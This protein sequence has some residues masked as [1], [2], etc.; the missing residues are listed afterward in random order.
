MH[1]SGDRRQ[2]EDRGTG[3]L[4]AFGE[5]WRNPANRARAPADGW[6]RGSRGDDS[7][8]WRGTGPRKLCPFRR[9]PR[10]ESPPPMHRRHSSP[11]TVA[12]VV[13]ALLAPPRHAAGA[14]FAQ[15]W[16]G[17][18][19]P[20]RAM[21]RE[22]P[23]TCEDDA[24]ESLAAQIDW[25]EHHVD[26]FG[27]IV[28][29]QPDVWGQS[30]LTRYRYEYETQLKAKLGDFQDLNNASIQRSDQSFVGIAMAMSGGHSTAATP[31]PAVTNVQN[32]IS[33]P[34]QASSGVIDRSAPFSAPQ[35][36]FASFGLG[37]DNAVSLDPSTHLDHLSEYIG[38]LQELRRINEGDD[39]ADSPGY[40]LN[41]V[42]VPVS[43]LPG[44]VTQTGYGAEITIIADVDLGDDLLPDT[45]RN[46]VIND[47]V[48]L[49]APPITFALNSGS[50]RAAICAQEAI[51]EA[52]A[53]LPPDALEFAAGGE[54]VAGVPRR[55]LVAEMRR[56]L[57]AHSMAVSIPTAKMRRARMPLPPEQIID[58]GGELQAA[59]LV[60]AAF[61]ALGGHPANRPCIEYVD[62]RGYLGEELQGAYDFLCQARQSAAW[63]R[64]AEH[65]LAELV[66]SRRFGE[67]ELRRREFFESLG[68]D[69]AV[70]GE[71]PGRA[72]SLVDPCD[73]PCANSVDG[74]RICRTTTAVLAWT[75][76]VES[77]LLNE[78]LV[79]D[80]RDAGSSRGTG[81][82]CVVAG[83]FW[84]P[85]PSPEARAAFNDYVRRRWPIR[86]FTL[87]PITQEQ[88][89]EDMFSQRREMQ[90]AM[91]MAFASGRVNSSAMTRYARRLETDIATIGLNKTAVGFTHGAD[92]FGW[93]FYP[94]VQT[95]PTKGNLQTFAETLCGPANSTKTAL[96][97]R[98][99]EPGMRECTAMIVMPSFV[100]G[101]TLDVRTNWFS[102]T[103]PRSTEQGMRET[104]KLSRS[105]KAMQRSAATC[106]RCAG[107]YRDG[108]VARLLRRVDQLDRELPLQTLQAQIP[109]ENTSAG[110]ELFD[111]GVTSLAPELIGY[112]GAE[113][114]DPT[115]STELFLIGKG[116]SI[117]DTNVIAGGKT[118]TATLISRDV[119]KAEVPPGVQIIPADTAATSPRVAR[120]LER[121]GRTLAGARPA[122]VA[123]QTASRRVSRS[124]VLTSHPEPIATPRESKGGNPLRDGAASVLEPETA[125]APTARRLQLPLPKVQ[126]E[127]RERLACRDSDDPCES[128][129]DPV[130]FVD[131]HLATPYG[132]SDHL[133]VPV[134]R[135]PASSAPGPARCD[136]A[137]EPGDT[138]G[139]TTTKTKTGGWRVNEY[140]EGTDDRIAIRAPDAFAAPAAAE[141]RC[142]V[143]DDGTGAT[144][145][146]FSVPAP[147]FLA[148][149]RAYVLGGSE[150]R[151]FVGDT[152]RPATDK[153]L[154]GALKPFIDHLG[155]LASA[156]GVPDVDR[157]LTLTADLVTG[158]QVIPIAGSVA[159][160]VRRA[161]QPDDPAAN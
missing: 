73:G 96:A 137:F 147:T 101:I 93:R 31:Q 133:L 81:P 140:Y 107:A 57:R 108:D 70:P 115:A 14:D 69:E 77:A 146:T 52:T 98:R 145:A 144:V 4:S 80:M 32:L 72:G 109:Y 118:V 110:F 159:I 51:Q 30:R 34:S 39:T 88:N 21:H 156:G 102:L 71:P 62:V 135:A 143:R 67:L 85:D 28:A 16:R 44:K 148:G 127:A 40:A 56:V 83:P 76:L 60:R 130:G 7:S 61:D 119:I 129:C 66:R 38:H 114:I 82:G 155:A 136:L 47:L 150:L 58:V 157:N 149:E 18:T 125:P 65:D 45:F 64:M 141:L 23:A 27:S 120:V 10:K 128:C 111:T 11:L 121:D 1:W 43:I 89:V 9:V 20:V 17:I 26:R 99:L 112:Y 15:V 122:A 41:L 94:R 154:R 59:I 78:R 79:A 113:G 103:D 25:L 6:G 53:V 160:R 116:F 24:V 158:Q 29:K 46:L 19:A 3:N 5:G 54:S 134:Y 90:M 153:T 36:P 12:A 35:K 55:Q 42:R 22:K 132:V 48:D 37:A 104:L 100:S 123:G 105:I 117:H 124:V 142:T 95:P 33:D 151:N 106:A 74:C 68:S 139:L 152:S 49:L 97:A 2:L 92:T 50:V 75:I 8:G 84:G 131:I 87:D 13:A 161:D 63:G 86:V 138:L 91:A 126:T